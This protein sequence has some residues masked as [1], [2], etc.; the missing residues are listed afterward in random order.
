MVEE[1]AKRLFEIPGL[2]YRTWK[3]IPRTEILNQES[4]IS[5]PESTVEYS[6]FIKIPPEFRS[7]RKP[8]EISEPSITRISTSSLHPFPQTIRDAVKK[9]VYGD[10]KV[11][12][13]LF[14]WLVPPECDLI[15]MTVWYKIADLAIVDDLVDR[16][17]A[18]EPSGADR[19]EYWMSAK[20]KHPKALSDYARFGKLDLRDVDVTVDVGVHNELKATIPTALVQRLKTFFDIMGETD[21]HQQ[22]KALPKLRQLALSGTAGREFKILVD[23]EALFFPEEFSKYVDV[24]KDFRFSTCYKGK[25]FYELP[26]PMIPKRMNIVSRADLTL[27]KPAVEGTLIYK[28]NLFV[29]AIK[30]VVC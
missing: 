27:E 5:V 29:D 28:S 18:H 7:I 25:E 3:N 22:F 19:N 1:I 20:L 26:V 2:L 13:A 8:I 14:P 30:K 17:G 12:Y 10:G 21:P 23:L 4:T 15:S 9:V 24:V 16:K 6:M 11:S